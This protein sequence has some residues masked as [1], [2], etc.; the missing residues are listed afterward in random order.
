MTEQLDLETIRPTSDERMMAALA[1]FFGIIGSLII[2]VIQKDKSRFVR[3]QAAQA[4]AFD[5]ITM[6]FMFALFFCLFGVMFLG[7]FGTIFAGVNNAAQ[8]ENVSWLIVLPMMF[9]FLMF[10]CIFPFSIA[11]FVAK[12]IATI[13]V[14]NSNNFHYP[15]LGPRVENFLSD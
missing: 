11:L 13:S 3:F 9:P 5:L 8:S 14:L 10:T 6:L 2:Y 7:M 4:L 12:I 1:H 15:W